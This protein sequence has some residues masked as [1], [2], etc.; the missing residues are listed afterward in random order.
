MRRKT[1]DFTD[2]ILY[3]KESQEIISRAIE[4]HNELGNGFHEK[5][6]ENA[7]VTEFQIR[8]SLFNNKD[9]SR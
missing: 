6:Y 9:A 8:K 5:P 2:K 3:K 7:F 1:T 4:V